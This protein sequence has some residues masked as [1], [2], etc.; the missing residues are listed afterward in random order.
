VDCGTYCGYS[1]LVLS[2]TLREIANELQNSTISEDEEIIDETFEFHIYTTEVSLKLANV[3]QSVFRMAKMEQVIT[4]ILMKADG[5]ESLSAALKENGVTG[6]DFLLLDHAKNLYLS[7][8]K[9]LEAAGLLK[10]GSR[11]AAD[12]VVFN[13]LDSYR[14]HMEMQ[15]AKGIV[16]TRLDEMNLEYSSNLKDGIEMTLYVKDP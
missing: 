12:N 13:K 4:P 6:V 2:S 5:K 1:A 14:Y 15:Q 9:D 11:V 3:A 7:D 8:V 10:A 16:E